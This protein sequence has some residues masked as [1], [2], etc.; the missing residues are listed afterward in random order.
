MGRFTPGGGGLMAVLGEG[1]ALL[2]PATDGEEQPEA[3]VGLQEHLL[4]LGE[5]STLKHAPKGLR[6]G[7]GAQRGNQQPGRHCSDGGTGWKASRAS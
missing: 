4:A 3:L 2:S 6:I 7:W 1:G 5:H